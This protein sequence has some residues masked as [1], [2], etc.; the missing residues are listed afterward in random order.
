MR[1]KSADHPT[2]SGLLDNNPWRGRVLIGGTVAVFVLLLVVEMLTLRSWFES[3]RDTDDLS[4]RAVDVSEL[5]NVHRQVF[6][7]VYATEN[8]DEFLDRNDIQLKRDL[9]ENHVRRLIDRSDSLDPVMVARLR[10][11]LDAYDAWLA[12]TEGMNEKELES[13]AGAGMGPANALELTVKLMYDQTEA[14]YVRATQVARDHQNESKAFLLVTTA[15]LGVFALVALVAARRAARAQRDDAYDAI[16]EREE[17]H[18]KVLDS[19]KDVVFTT[20]VEGRWTY[21]SAAWER[22]T[23]HAVADT[24][25]RRFL[26]FIHPA[27]RDDT[28]AHFQ[29]TVAVPAKERRHEVRYM[30]SDGSHVWVEVWVSSESGSGVAAGTLVDITDRRRYEAELHHQATHDT[31]TGLPNRDQLADRLDDVIS[32]SAGNGRRAGVL[33]LDL[34]RF[35]LVNDSLGHDTGDLVLVEVARRLEQELTDGQFAARFGGDEFVVVAPD[36]DHEPVEVVAQLRRLSK[37]LEA[38]VARPFELG[39]S[40]ATLTTSVGLTVSRDD[41]R[42]DEL[43]AEA[44]AAMY[45]AKQQGKSRHE[46]FDER[47]RAG[48]DHRL[49]LEHALRAARADG[50]L[51]LL[52]Q[53]IVDAMDL[54]RRGTEALL[55]WDHPTRGILRPGAFLE[56][57]EEAGVMLDLGEWVLH[58]A[59]ADVARF[60]RWRADQTVAVNLTVRELCSNHLLRMVEDALGANGIPPHALVVEV[61]EHGVVDSRAEA[62]HNLHA[63]REMG[64]RVAIDDFGTGYSALATLR[65]L[66]AD[67]LKIDLTF[68]KGLDHAETAEP[69]RAIASSVTELGRTLGLVIVA[70]GVE[71]ARQ[72]DILREIGVDQVQGNYV[73]PPIDADL[74]LASTDDVLDAAPG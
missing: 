4:K 22:L 14:P 44:D 20:D 47:L 38:A 67:Q 28:E 53:P 15:L 62:I 54:R 30:R 72:L 48:A 42:A 8:I 66:P 41:A 63:L 21:L 17:Q 27:D 32:K 11:D 16:A 49:H 34:D 40:R 70:E 58:Q 3:R 33:F 68:I 37:T 26:D 73:C 55:R 29:G 12:S 50:Q 5:A 18:R 19:V 74:L 23:G 6:E 46:V 13:A 35:K 25:G 2:D 10:A 71:S 1:S 31:L 51:R 65:T 43:I 7:L 36:L 60:R 24:I 59:C 56:V 9:L 52:H 45:Q 57:A 39:A 69:D 61:T 64:V